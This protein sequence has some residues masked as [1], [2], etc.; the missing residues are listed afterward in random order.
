MK[1]R[2]PEHEEEEEVEERVAEMQ[3]GRALK[4]VET[5]VMRMMYSGS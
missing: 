1:E 3:K 2:R 4:A 5:W